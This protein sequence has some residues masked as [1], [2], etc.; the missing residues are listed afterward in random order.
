M[1]STISGYQVKAEVNGIDYILYTEKGFRGFNIP[2]HV[3]YDG[4]EWHVSVQG[5][6]VP[7]RCAV[8]ML[9]AYS[10][11]RVPGYVKGVTH[12]RV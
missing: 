2:C 9:P 3:S 6:D 5:Q 12:D 8:A 7:V 11:E 4:K 1:Q 10:E